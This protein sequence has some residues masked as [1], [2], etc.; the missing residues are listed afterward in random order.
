MASAVKKMQE[1]LFRR[2]DSSPSPSCPSPEPQQNERAEPALTINIPGKTPPTPTQPPPKLRPADVAPKE[3]GENQQYSSY[4]ER[5][6]ATLGNAYKGAER[7]RLL[8]DDRRERH[9]KRWGP[10]LSDRQWVGVIATRVQA[11]VTPAFK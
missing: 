2:G 6:T 9:W 10:Y 5:L 11:V 8:Q 4:R 7:F 3:S 1:R